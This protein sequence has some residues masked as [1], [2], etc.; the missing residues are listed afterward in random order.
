MFVYNYFF[1]NCNAAQFDESLERVRSSTGSAISGIDK[2]GSMSNITRDEEGACA[3]HPL[4]DALNE[5]DQSVITALGESVALDKS[6]I[7]VLQ[8]SYESYSPDPI[9]TAPGERL[10]MMARE[11]DIASS[12]AVQADTA[13][14]GL[15]E[16]TSDDLQKGALTEGAD[17]ANKD[18]E[19]NMIL[20][21][22]TENIVD[23]NGIPAE[24]EEKRRSK[25]SEQASP[26][27]LNRMS[28]GKLPGAEDTPAEAV[29]EELAPI[30]LPI[31]KAGS[32]PVSNQ[33]QISED[34]EKTLA[35]FLKKHKFKDINEV[36]QPGKS[37]VCGPR[38]NGGTPLHKAVE[39]NDQ[40]VIRI[41][42]KK[43]VDTSKVDGFERTPSKMAQEKDM[44]P[45]LV[46]S[47]SSSFSGKTKSIPSPESRPNPIVEGETAIAAA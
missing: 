25:L 42:L 4:I 38:T 26:I 36:K 6:Q 44:N 23:D 46:K 14:D 28:E 17:D 40:E 35:A 21:A 9:A 8:R 45:V 20:N 7:S 19:A 2:T 31:Q 41:L 22:S 15:T 11:S 12:V 29:K 24:T 33:V 1:N 32:T 3:A 37:C 18:S 34:E 13:A 47:L 39:L 16:M 5:L 27:S 43:N 10:T 30:S